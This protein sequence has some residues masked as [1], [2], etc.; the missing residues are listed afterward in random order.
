ML[1]CAFNVPSALSSLTTAVNEHLCHQSL[2]PLLAETANNS[3]KIDLAP[4]NRSRTPILHQVIADGKVSKGSASGTGGQGGQQG[5]LIKAIKKVMTPDILRRAR[6]MTGN[7]ATA[8][9]AAATAKIVHDP[10]TNVGERL[11][12]TLTAAAEIRKKTVSSTA[13]SS[14]GSKKPNLIPGHGENW[15]VKV[16]KP[17]PFSFDKKSTSQHQNQPLKANS[18]KID[19]TKM[20]R[21][22]QGQQQQQQQQQPL[23]RKTTTTTTTHTERLI[24]SKILLTRA[25]L[26][27]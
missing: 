20:L 15:V 16:T 17:T 21:T 27:Q 22:Y 11:S 25:F 23:I 19:F 14:Q 24:C 8:A 3:P 12:K 1:W 2:S 18:D 7:S 26:S 9:S 13:A 5:K 4:R 10:S 6:K